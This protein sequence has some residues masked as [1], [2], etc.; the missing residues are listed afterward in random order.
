M[1]SKTMCEFSPSGNQSRPAIS[2]LLYNLRGK[3][4]V[5]KIMFGKDRQYDKFK[6]GN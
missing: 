5:Y 6:V 2:K 3:C 1:H 4:T